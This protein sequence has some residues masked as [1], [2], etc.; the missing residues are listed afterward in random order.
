MESTRAFR[1]LGNLKFQDVSEQWGLDHLGVSFGCAVV[2]LDGDGDLDIVYNNFEGPP[3]LLRNNTTSGHRVLIKLAGRP[4]NRDAIGAEL[5]IETASGIQVRQVYTERGVVASEPAT[6]HFGLG[7]DTV[8]AKLTLHWPNGQLQVLEDLPVDRQLTIAQPALAAGQVSKR[9]PARFNRPPGPAALFAENAHER[10]LS[11]TDTPQAVDE[12][13]RQRLLPRRLGL[14]GPAIA[15]ADVNGDGL[16]DVFVGGTGGQSSVLYLGQ[17]DGS[18]KAGA[19]PAS[20]RG[21]GRRRCWRPPSTRPA[22]ARSTSCRRRRRP[23][24][25]G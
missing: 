6:V 5:R 19:G 9:P 11:F 20:G 1:N 25:A 16:P 17:P 8:I 3:T 15:V 7:N 2:D 13:T 18:F 10:G 14:T 24:R 12:F 23:A 21:E 22:T 4:P